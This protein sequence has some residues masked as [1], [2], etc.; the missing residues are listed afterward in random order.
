MLEW[1]RQEGKNIS[2]ENTDVIA[3]IL[4]GKQLLF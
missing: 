2:N 4:K 3:D 1:R